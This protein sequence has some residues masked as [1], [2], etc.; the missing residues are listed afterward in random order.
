MGRGSVVGAGWGGHGAQKLG[1]RVDLNEP[2][3]VEHEEREAQDR[4]IDLHGPALDDEKPAAR[5]HGGQCGPRRGRRTCAAP[6]GGSGHGGAGMAGRGH[7][8]AGQLET[9]C[10]RAHW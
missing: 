10:E 1:G 7:G 6:T 9:P 3:A 2:V 8:A 5:A 4:D